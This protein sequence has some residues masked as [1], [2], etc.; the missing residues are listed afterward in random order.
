MITPE[1][2]E[3]LGSQEDQESVL[4]LETVEEVEPP[5]EP[6]QESYY[7]I[8]LDRAVEQSRSLAVLLSSRRCASCKEQLESSAE[9]PSAEEQIKAIAGCC[10]TRE[11]FIRAEMPVQEIVFRTILSNSNKLVSLEKLHEDVT[12]RWYTPLN[13]RTISASGLKRVLDRDVY[14]G[15]T[16]VLLAPAK[17]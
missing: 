12:E 15:F 10:A 9:L 1:E 2:M 4:A 8:D 6:E 11:G 17:S 7:K 14:Y 13:P 3:D 16:E 5:P